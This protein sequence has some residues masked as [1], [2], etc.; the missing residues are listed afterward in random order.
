MSGASSMRNAVK[1]ITHKERAQPSSRKKLG[2][3]EKHK[4]YVVRAK[5]YHKKQQYIKNLRKKAAERNPDE[6]YFKMNTSKVENGVHRDIIEN[7]GSIDAKTLNLLKTQDV[8]YLIH[9]KSVDI[10]KAEK[11]KDGLHMI[12]DKQPREHKI[13]VDTPE[14]IES[15]DV[16]S[17]FGTTEDLSNRTFNRIRT[18]QIEKGVI[19]DNATIQQV[20]KALKSSKQSY[21]ELNKRLKR[22]TK[23]NTAIKSIQLDRNLASK[24]S[25]RKVGEGKDGVPIYKWKRQRNS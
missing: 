12:G 4:D 24:G 25:K 13:F 22:S 19:S 16:A 10:R 1:R 7:S 18:E 8:G 6:F 9:R 21:T 17:H 14:D 11:L 23:L 2:L 3:L 20:K 15:F 5:D